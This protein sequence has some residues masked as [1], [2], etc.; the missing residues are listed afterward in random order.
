MGE[1]DFFSSIFLLERETVLSYR[2]QNVS[3]CPTECCVEVH[4]RTDAYESL[5]KA[6]NS[7]EVELL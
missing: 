4:M 6:L 1:E 7:L 2:T 5:R 3:M